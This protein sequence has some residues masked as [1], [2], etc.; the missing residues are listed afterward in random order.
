[1]ELS[2]FS[3]QANAPSDLSRPPTALMLVV[4]YVASSLE[5]SLISHVWVNGCCSWSEIC[6]RK[7]IG[8]EHLHF[9]HPCDHAHHM[10]KL[11]G[12][13][14]L[15]VL[16]RRR[17]VFIGLVGGIDILAIKGSDGT[18]RGASG[19]AVRGMLIA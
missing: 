15:V 19:C 8:E 10:L 5:P 6:S 16:P 1:L 2:V 4:L 3:S 12:V 14:E 17:I 13:I 9:L 18:C 7:S 11:Y